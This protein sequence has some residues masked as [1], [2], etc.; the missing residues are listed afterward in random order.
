VRVAALCGRASC[1][2]RY[3]EMRQPL[4]VGAACSV[5]WDA[6][7]TSEKWLTGRLNSSRDAISETALKAIT[8]ASLSSLPSAGTFS[9]SDLFSEEEYVDVDN[10]AACCEKCIEQFYYVDN[11]G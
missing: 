11:N 5:W 7:A 3:C 10:L 4:Q 8:S 6:A 2:C 9:S 1:E